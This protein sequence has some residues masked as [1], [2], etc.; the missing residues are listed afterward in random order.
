VHPSP[1]FKLIW[2][3]PAVLSIS[4]DLS[5]STN[6]NRVVAHTPL[7][8]V[9]GIVLGVRHTENGDHFLVL[10]LR[11]YCLLTLISITKVVR[12]VKTQ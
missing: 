5:V 1:G 10:R 3:R 11:L 7:A 12:F 6:R 4:T 8:T 9:I 2:A